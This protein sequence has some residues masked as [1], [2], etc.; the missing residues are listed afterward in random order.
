MRF[1]PAQ[2][3][4]V[5]IPALVL[6]ALFL[7]PA[8]VEAQ[9]FGAWLTLAGVPQ[10]GY[11][12]VPHSAAL[13]PTTAITIE[14]WVNLRDADGTSGCSS[15]VGKNWQQAWWVGICGTSLRSYLMGSG[16][17]HTS[18]TIP[19]NQWT[20]L[21]VVYDGAHRFHYINGELIQSW[22]ESGPL[23]SSTA[24]VRIGSDVQW[25]FT[26][27]GT[28]DEVRIWNVARNLS[29][30]RSTI[31]VPLTGSEPGLVAL[32]RLDG[33]PNS[34]T[35]AHNGTLQGSGVTFFTFPVTLNCGTSTSTSLCL[36]D[37]FAVSAR[38][39]TG[40][41]GTAEGTAQVV[42]CPND[43]SGLFWFFSPDNWEIQAK[44]IDGCGLNDRFWVFSAATT[45]VFYRMEVLDVRAGV[46]KVYFNYPGPPAPAVTDTSAF[47]TCP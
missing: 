36:L 29:Q 1:R 10:H 13:N 45:N 47:A 19:N 34:G 41:P 14:A 27:D 7:A 40:A 39:R 2:A 9:P 3:R 6:G 18:G 37:H 23:T 43:G 46:N 4:F 26:P 11:I 35:G 22:A 15:I 25:E 38:F 31:N 30:L 32:Y 17:Q 33:N 20:H 28:I 42:N 44:V 21:A 5:V 8:V 12:E 24:P 16:S